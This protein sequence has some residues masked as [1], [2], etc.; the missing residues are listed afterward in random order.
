MSGV[1]FVDAR[2]SEMAAGAANVLVM[3]CSM[4]RGW[5]TRLLN[6]VA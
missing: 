2:V 1:L 6:V 4:G 5:W 3:D